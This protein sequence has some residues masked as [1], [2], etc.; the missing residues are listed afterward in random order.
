MNIHPVKNEKDYEAALSRIEELWGAELGTP[1]GDELDVWLTLVEAYEDEH[2]PVPPPSPVAAIKFV[3][4]QK[5]LTQTDLV[6]YFG[7]RPRVSEVLSGKRPLTLSMIRSLS[8]GLGLPAEIL[9]QD[10]SQLPEEGKA[11]DWSKFPV[12][13]IVDRGWVAGFD[14]KTQPEEIMR[15]LATQANADDYLYSNSACLRQ[16]TRRSHKDDPYA[17]QAW[18]LGVLLKANEMDLL[19]EYHEDEIELE[20]L[21]KVAHLSVLSDGP[22]QAAEYLSRKGIKLVVV[23][24]FKK[25]YLDGAVLINKDGSPVIGLSLRYNRT[26][27]FWFTLIHELAHLACGHVDQAQD[28]CIIDDLD[29]HTALDKTENEADETAE[30][31]LIPRELWDE[32]PAKDTAK[33]KDVRALARQA[34]VNPAIVAGRIRYKRGNYR[35][36]AKHVGHGEVRKLFE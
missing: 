12:K 35:L 9:I 1:A 17:L 28:K 33:I 34:D 36:L 15:H 16:G 21:R 2:H 8:S 25:T 4:E 27:N 31:A 20:F 29:L 22:V 5:G 23:R 19:G 18:I 32:H 6:P 26:D 10:D 7:S 3:M 14:H 24:H 30:A 13:E 11:I